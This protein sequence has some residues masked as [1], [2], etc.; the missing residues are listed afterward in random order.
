[1]RG[2]PDLSRGPFVRLK[3]A[4]L[5]S[6]RTAAAQP[7]THCP[8]AVFSSWLPRRPPPSLVGCCLVCRRKQ[9]KEASTGSEGDP[10][11]IISLFRNFIIV[12]ATVGSLN[13]CSTTADS[14]NQS[15]DTT[16]QQ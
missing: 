1:M 16:A 9:S 4:G 6:G 11:S 15:T 5:A 14:I 12:I 10:S 3:I 7:T 13:F 2:D 8:R